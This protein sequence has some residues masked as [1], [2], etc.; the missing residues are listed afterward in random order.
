MDELLHQITAEVTKHISEPTLI[1]VSGITGSARM[2]CIGECCYIVTIRDGH[3][4]CNRYTQS[5]LLNHVLDFDL[6]DPSVSPKTIA[7][8]ISVDAEDWENEIS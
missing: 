8:R 4:A 1:D 7:A 6:S 2:V 3:L 5:D